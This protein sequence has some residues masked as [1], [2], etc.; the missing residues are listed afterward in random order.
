MRVKLLS[1]MR[2][3]HQISNLGHLFSFLIRELA[4]LSQAG[5][6]ATQMIEWLSI[7]PLEEPVEET[8]RNRTSRRD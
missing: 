5:E 6:R 4:N 8:S 2:A 3:P 1:H 7:H